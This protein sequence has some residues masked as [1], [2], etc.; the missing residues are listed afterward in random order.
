MKKRLLF[1]ATGILC[2][3]FA[4]A[5]ELITGDWKTVDDKTGSNFSVVRIYQGSDG[6]YYGQIARMLVGE[7]GMRCE[8][9]TGEDANVPLEGLIIIRGMA[10]NAAKNQLEGGKVLDP[11][12]GKFYFGKIYPKDGKLVL[13]GSIDK[14]GIFGRNQEWIR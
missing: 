7:P 13:R 3:L 14:H 11:E 1:I 5:Q 2:S 8:A 4:Y 6:F 12:S 10:Y 9:C